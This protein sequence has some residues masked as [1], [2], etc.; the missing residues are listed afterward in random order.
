MSSLTSR[1]VMAI[2]IRQNGPNGRTKRLQGVLSFTQRSDGLEVKMIGPDR[3]E[4]VTETFEH[5]NVI[6]GSADLETR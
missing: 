6:G 1:P 4:T 5:A 3:D 2:T